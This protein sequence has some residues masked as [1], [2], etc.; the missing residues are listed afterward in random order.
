MSSCKWW[1]QVQPSVS[2]CSVVAHGL[3]HVKVQTPF[4]SV[5][6][7]PWGYRLGSSV[8]SY[9]LLKKITL[10]KKKVKRKQSFS[11]HPSITTALDD[12]IV[13]LTA[14][15]SNSLLH[16]ELAGTLGWLAHTHSCLQRLC[17]DA[18]YWKNYTFSKVQIRH[19]WKS[20]FKDQFNIFC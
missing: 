2:S 13:M 17:S 3:S 12:A 8:L 9:T 11:P 4:F 16:W 10:K 5:Q 20:H 19:F 15:L 1:M 6:Q 7:H 18:A 14:V